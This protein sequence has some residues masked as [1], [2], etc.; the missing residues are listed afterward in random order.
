MSGKVNLSN[1]KCVDGSVIGVAE[2]DNPKSLNALGYEMIKQLYEQLLRWQSDDNVVAVFLHGKGEKAFCAGGDIQ[3]IYQ[4]LLNKEEDAETARNAMEEFFSLEYRCDYLIHTYSKPVIAWGHG[5]LMGG[6]VGLFMGAAKRVAASNTRFAMP[7][8]KIGLYPDVGATYFLN[9]LPKHT[10]LFLALTS[11]Q[12]NAADME[13]LGMCQW[14]AEPSDK[15]AVLDQLREICWHSEGDRSAVIDQVLDKF[16]CEE[17]VDGLMLA[18]EEQIKQ[19][20]QTGDLAVTVNS[21]LNAEGGDK[22]FKQAQG[23]LA[24]GSPLS[25]QISYQQLTQY[26]DLSLEECFRLEFALTIHCG[27]EGDFREGVRSLLVDK[28][29]DPAWMH[30]NVTEVSPEL[31]Q[32]FFSPICSAQQLLSHESMEEKV[33]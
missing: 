4:V 27:M 9:K 3:A 6:G 10:A 24:Y 17:S 14:I 25:M 22:W 32:R 19:L 29:L 16:E 30:Q 21:I 23:S 33:S 7:E 28:S 2:L 11:A 15:E 13:A 20:C 12:I 8:V 31:L 1:L 26:S 18:H 5:Y